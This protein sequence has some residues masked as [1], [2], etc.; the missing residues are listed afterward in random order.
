M[1]LVNSV[2]CGG[3]TDCIAKLLALLTYCA[4]CTLKL[5]AS[6]FVFQQ[7]STGVTSS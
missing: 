5:T 3:A 6:Y 4:D 1:H 7:T 2:P